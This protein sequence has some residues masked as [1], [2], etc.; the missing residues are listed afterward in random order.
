MLARLKNSTTRAGKDEG[1]AWHV[2]FRNLETLPDT[3][4]VR[5]NFLFNTVAVAI[6][7]G[8]MLYL[9]Y[10]QITIS[11]V[12]A[13]IEIIKSRINVAKAPSDRAVAQFQLFKAEEKLFRDAQIIKNDGFSFPDF[14][15]HLAS[16]MP[17]GVKATRVEFRGIGQTILVTGY[18][19]GQDAVASQTAS[20]FFDALLKDETFKNRFSSIVNSNLGRN[21][22]ENS[23]SFELVFT[24]KK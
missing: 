11:S 24:F 8:L 7:A 17:E 20:A 21:V 14:L 1:P 16:L 12:R 9:A 4:T 22:A 6:L 10:Q 19:A 13:E 5:T 15:I 18:V 23:L 3:K 2:D